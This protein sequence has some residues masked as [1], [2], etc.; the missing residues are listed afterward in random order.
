VR[1]LPLSP[2]HLWRLVNGGR[3]GQ[4]SSQLSLSVDTSSTRSTV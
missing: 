2:A 3:A 1:E 4:P